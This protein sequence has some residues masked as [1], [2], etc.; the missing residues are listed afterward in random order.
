MKVLNKRDVAVGVGAYIGRGSLWGNPYVI[1]KH[2]DRD[3]VIR[4]FR[5]YASA[6]ILDRPDWL[7]P[8]EGR[9][10]VC[11]CAPLACHGDVL[12]EMIGEKK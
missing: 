9:D 4:K 2:G 5:E 11:F 1:G 6:V 12:L 8:L 10:L 3:E 7:V